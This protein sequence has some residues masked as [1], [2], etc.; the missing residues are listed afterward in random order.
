MKISTLVEC[1]HNIGMG[2]KIEAYP[3]RKKHEV[4]EVVLLRM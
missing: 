4:D 3:K 2:V 1:L